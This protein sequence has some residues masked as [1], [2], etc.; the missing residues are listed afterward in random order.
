MS[1]SDVIYAKERNPELHDKKDEILGQMK[2]LNIIAKARSF[3][4]N[5]VKV[6]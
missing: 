5:G 2:D 1:S 6:S 4:E 3:D